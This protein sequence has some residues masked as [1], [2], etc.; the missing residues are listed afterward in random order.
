[1]TFI[2][3]HAHLDSEQFAGDVDQVVARARKAG[4]T[5]IINIAID[6]THIGPVLALAEKYEGC[7]AVVGIHPHASGRWRDKLDEGLAQVEEALAHERVVAVGEM[8]LDFYRDY[9]PHH[10]QEEVFRA[11][12]RLA[13]R[14][15]MPIVIHNRQADERLLAIVDEERAAGQGPETGVIH[16]FSGGPDFALECVRRGF[17]LGFGGV[18]TYPAAEGVREAAAAVPLDRILLETDAPYLAPQSRRGK[19]NEP[20]FMV[21]TAQVLA[22]VR[23]LS[24]EEV[25][26]RTTANARRLFGLPGNES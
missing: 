5:G 21:E 25:A 16:C 14:M 9:V 12:L 3:T 10:I 19:R 11:Q 1:M 2:D 18:L 23:G 15:D 26:D 13:A 4:V 8:G 7:W 20:A 24:L 6:P 17:Y 22:R